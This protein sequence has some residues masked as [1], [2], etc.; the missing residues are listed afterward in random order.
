MDRKFICDECPKIYSSRQGRW[1]HKKNKHAKSV[2]SQR[3]KGGDLQTDDTLRKIMKMLKTSGDES[4]EDKT[5]VEQPWTEKILKKNEEPKIDNRPRDTAM[6]EDITLNDREKFMR[7]LDDLKKKLGKESFEDLDDLVPEYWNNKAEIRNF[8][9]QRV[10][11][12]IGDEILD[13]LRGLQR[14]MPL[15]SLEMQ[16]LL[17]FMDKKRQALNK[18]IEI[19]ESKDQSD[20]LEKMADKGIITD[21]EKYELMNNLNRET[22]TK[23]LS[24]RVFDVNEK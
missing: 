17:N 4:V 6:F 5:E 14:F 23:I 13:R 16:M 21:A 11:D 3:N 1:R 12:V 9:W 24:R 7:L 2:P 19:M 18:L 10:G 15:V 20:L 22:I 8:R